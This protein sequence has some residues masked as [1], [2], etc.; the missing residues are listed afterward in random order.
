VDES[1]AVIRGARITIDGSPYAS[2]VDPHVPNGPYLIEGLAPGRHRVHIETSLGPP[3]DITID[4]VSGDNPIPVRVDAG[5]RID[6]LAVDRQGLAVGQTLVS[7][8]RESSGGGAGDARTMRTADGGEFAFGNLTAGPW[9]VVASAIGAATVE[10]LVVN[11]PAR[12]LR[13]TLARLGRARMQLVRDAGGPVEGDY[14]TRRMRADGDVIHGSGTIAA[15]IVTVEGFDGQPES[16]EIS[17]AGYSPVVKEVRVPP[18]GETDLGA[19][20][21]RKGRHLKGV[22]VGADGLPV[23]GAFVL[24]GHLGRV[25][26]DQHGAFE[27]PG[28]PLGR[29]SL[30]VVSEFHLKKSIEVGDESAGPLRIELSSGAHVE[31]TVVGADGQG[32]GGLV[33]SFL[34]I[35]GEQVGEVAERLRTD[36]DGSFEVR[37][38]PGRYRIEAK[39]DG[40]AAPVLLTDLT[41]AEGDE[42]KPTLVHRPR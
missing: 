5:I 26:S 27:F 15:G 16:L 38:S 3:Q 22:V 9:R 36:E 17:V 6:G 2:A 39:D 37:I 33:V 21:M 8:E 10:P 23:Q 40:D 12:G 24:V 28:V 14:E 4:A 7:I 20:V 31:G 41:L 1:G 30:L 25:V 11:A 42:R 29:L 19:V 34:P 18:E 32:I 35:D 13:L